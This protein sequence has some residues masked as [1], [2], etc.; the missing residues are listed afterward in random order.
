MRRRLIICAALGILAL[1]FALA[2]N[3][4]CF[5][6]GPDGAGWQAYLD[7]QW[8]DRAAYSQEGVDA[9]QGDFDAY[10]PL[11]ADYTIPGA[12]YRLLGRAHAPGQRAMYAGYVA[13]LVVLVFA[14]G[15]WFGL[16]PP[17]ALLASLI[18]GFFLP[19]FVVHREALTFHFLHLNPHWMEL[20]IFSLLAIWSVWA[21]DGR[22][23]LSRWLLICVPAACITIEVLGVGAMVIFTPWVVVYSGVSLFFSRNR[24]ALVQKLLSAIVVIITIVVS[25]Q[26]AYLLGLERYSAYNVFGHEFDWDLPTL[27]RMSIFF[28]LPYGRLLIILGIIGAVLAIVRDRGRLRQLGI[29]HLVAVATFAAAATAFYFVMS[30]GYRTSSPLYFETTLL[31]FAVMFSAYAIVELVWRAGGRVRNLPYSLASELALWGVL[32]VVAGYNAFSAAGFVRD[33]CRPQ[34]IYDRLGVNQVVSKMQATIALKPGVVFSGNEAT[35][36]WVDDQKRVDFG[37]MNDNNR[38]RF[39]QTGNETRLYGLWHYDIPTMYQYFTF[40]TAPYYLFM[41]DFLSR[42]QDWQTRSGLVLTHIDPRI[43]RL[44][45]V[46]YVVTNHSSSAGREVV[47]QQLE[48]GETLRLIEL[49]SPNLGNYSPTSVIRVDSFHDGLLRIHDSK[50]D[51][52]STVVTDSTDPAI[53]GPLIPATNA[54]LTYETYGFRLQANSTGKSLLIVPAQFS[55]CWSVEGSGSPQ[56][57]RANTLQLGVAFTGDID[58]R[59]VFRYGPLFA[60]SCRLR[61]VADMQR[62]DIAHGRVVPRT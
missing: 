30:G 52:R 54:R 61:D 51:G 35:M 46:R 36:D 21:L 3:R 59:L 20:I 19:P 50:F 2:V 9:H 24:T 4:N 14:A 23:S 17:V 34:Q 62:L 6:L 1:A 31:P 58:A 10:Y 45:G 43:L 44:L 5:E 8:A 7:Y 48:R 39:N 22:W 11:V 53:D 27:G 16:A 37:E 18:S 55:R 38:I 28:H 15:R 47:L 33:E 32:V 60:A 57:F 49:P 42:P 13:V 41:T 25:G 40:I 26:A 12:F 56:L 29:A